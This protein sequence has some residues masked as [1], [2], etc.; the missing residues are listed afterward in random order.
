MELMKEL[1][2]K[3]P[4]PDKGNIFLRLFKV[5]GTLVVSLLNGARVA[6]GH[7]PSDSP[8]R[9]CIPVVGKKL[10]AARRV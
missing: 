5:C 1:T 8:I 2:V 9:D 7:I 4:S 3:Q 6:V 10:V